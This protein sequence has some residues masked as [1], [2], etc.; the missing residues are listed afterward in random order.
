MESSS[1]MLLVLIAAVLLL[2]VLIIKAKLNAFVALIVTCIFVGMASGME[3]PKIVTSIE[4]GMAS[5]LGFL[6]TIV[7]FGTILG[8]MLEVSGG[9]ECL[10]RTLLDRM[11]PERAPWVMTLVGLI[12]GIPVFFEVGFVLLFPLVFIV[13]R[14]AKLSLLYVGVPLAVSL[15]VVHCMVPPHPAAFAITS[16]LGAD[17]GKV[18]L[19]AL[20]IGAPSAVIAGPV[21][22]G[23]ISS[24]CQ[25]GH[26][27][28]RD[29]EAPTPYD[30]L[31]G[32]GIT[33]FTVLLPLFIMVGK[34]LS[35]LILP[36][37]SPALPAIE[38]FGSPL[39]AL[40]I[41]VFF[42]YYTLGFARGKTKNELQKLTDN[43][44]GPIAGILLIIGAGGAFNQLLIDSGLG[45][46]FAD[47]LISLHMNPVFMAWL[48][49]FLLHL[50]IGSATVAMISSAG[51]VLPMLA[52]FPEISPEIIVLAIGSGAIGPCHVNDSSFWFIKEFL[53]ISLPDMFKSFTMACMIASFVSLAIIMVVTF[54]F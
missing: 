23:F 8:K 9:A 10:A 35:V 18:I 39:V 48:I 3:L 20:I 29:V 19:Y 40:L 21:W 33:L 30:Q 43:C 15:M 22:S 11:G 12:A 54:I 46:T 53:G 45:K 24:R 41:S 5:T 44:F 51:M 38:F 49:A 2:L 14:E 34:T 1:V 42:A 16:I 27:P 28:E 7:G 31:P 50:A 36:P 17:V 13:A 26:L 4:A 25:S 6:A 52:S 47:T 37:D 32:F